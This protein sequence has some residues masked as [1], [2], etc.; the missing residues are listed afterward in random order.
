MKDE[1]Y[2]KLDS[3]GIKYDKRW[4]AEKLQALI[5]DYTRGGIGAKVPVIVPS[6][7]DVSVE[8]PIKKEE[9][10]K[11]VAIFKTRTIDGDRMTYRYVGEGTLDEALS[12]V[13]EEPEESVGQAWPRGCNCLVNIKVKQ[14]VYEFDRAIAP[15]VVKAILEDKN[16]PLVRKLFG[17]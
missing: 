6:T 17:L 7:V 2:Q 16:V 1:L 11:V 10:F 12:V 14:G 8:K 5:E 9:P 15:H 4:R 13:C 3:L